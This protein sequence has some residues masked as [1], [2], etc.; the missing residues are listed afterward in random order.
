MFLCFSYLEQSGYNLLRAVETGDVGMVGR[1]LSFG[2]SQDVRSSNDI[3]NG[4]PLHVTARNNSTEVA[5]LLI[6]H[7]ADIEAR[8]DDNQTPLCETA[9]N[10]CTEVA[11]LLI[12]HVADSEARNINNQTP[13][14]AA[15]INN[16]TEVAQLLITHRADIEAR[17]EYNRTPL[18]VARNSRRNTEAVIRLF[19][20]H[21][22]NTS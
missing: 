5:Q 16:S 8:N 3:F 6:I 1:L 7:R 4:R 17:D 10:N 12:T 20:E 14:Y 15:A 19:T 22:A 11:Q 21:T 13:L 18:G 2:V 9:R